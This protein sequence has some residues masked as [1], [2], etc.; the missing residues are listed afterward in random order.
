MLFGKHKEKVYENC[1]N[2]KGVFNNTVET[3]LPQTVVAKAVEAHFKNQ[4]GKT[5]K[6]LLIGFDGARADTMHLLC[7]SEDAAV[8][9]LLFTSAYSAVNTL[10]AEG[11]LYLSFAGGEGEHL[12]G[13]ATQQGWASILTGEWGYLNGVVEHTPLKTDHPTILRKLAQSGKNTAFLGEWADHFTITYKEEIAIAKEQNLPLSFVRTDSDEK[14]QSLF[15]AEIEKGT[16]CIFGIFEAPDT[17]G[18]NTGF[19]L[20]NPRY[21]SCIQRLDNL[22]YALIEAVRARET[23]EEEDWLILITADHG[24]SNRGHGSQKLEDRMTFIASN[25][26]LI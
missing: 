5:P 22:S 14:L 9:G 23:Y 17:N 24:G 15:K 18:H 11:G 13:T 1:L 6:A 3:A 21:A 4:S 2:T 10:K 8:T 12:Q 20:S 19:S 25:K 7:E 16:D 26:A